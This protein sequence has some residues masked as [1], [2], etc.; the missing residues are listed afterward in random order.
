MAHVET[1]TP[2][3]VER[4]KEVAPLS[5]VAKLFGAL[6][7]AGLVILGIFVARHFATKESS[8][9]PEETR[10]KAHERERLRAEANRPPAPP[11]GS[12]GAKS[13]GSII[14]DDMPRRI[15]DFPGEAA[16]RGVEFLDRVL[17]A[18]KTGR[19]GRSNLP[20]PPEGT[21]E[22]RLHP[23]LV[24]WEKALRPGEPTPWFEAVEAIHLFV[25]TDGKGRQSLEGY[26]G[27]PAIWRFVELSP[28]GVPTARVSGEKLR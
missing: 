5:D 8:S 25:N 27:N 28:G 22:V 12:A 13:S 14:P 1:P 9:S 24:I 26:P 15:V 17:P 19:S 6:L 10:L 21:I 18:E 7:I 16:R 11:N 20:R 3:G 2:K 23:G 4:E